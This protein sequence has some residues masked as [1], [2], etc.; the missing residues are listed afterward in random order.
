MKKFV[1]MLAVT[2]ALLTNASTRADYTLNFGPVTGG[3]VVFTGTGNTFMF[4]N[5]YSATP[6][7]IF[8]VTSAST[9][10]SFPQPVLNLIGSITT[11][12]ANTVFT[13]TNV[14]VPT[15][16]G[17]VITPAGTKLT[18]HDGVHGSDF[19]FTADL[20]FTKIYTKDT[21]VGVE[22]GGIVNLTNFDYQGTNVDL[23]ELATYPGGFL[24]ASIQFVNPSKSLSDL[25]EDG[26]VNKSSYSATL[27]AVPVPP[28]F[29]LMLT[30]GVLAGGVRALRR[31]RFLAL[32]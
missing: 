22:S 24:V 11:G 28:S 16:T 12:G 2:A 21:T 15:Q 18:I 20:D 27:S 23:L 13:I 3:E 10:S 29:V 31:R 4:H 9:G 25:T 19:D 7:D 32:A 14:D 30:G 8:K 17:D 1:W 26:A 5:Q 6:L